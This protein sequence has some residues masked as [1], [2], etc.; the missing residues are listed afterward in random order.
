MVG[1]ES[2]SAT[3]WNTS[4]DV[5][6]FRLNS[7]SFSAS[8]ELSLSP[9]LELDIT[10]LDVN[11]LTARVDI[12]TPQ[13]AANASVVANVNRQC[14]PI[15]PNDFESFTAALTFGASAAIDIEVSTS[16]KLVPDLDDQIFT[17]NITL[18][19]LPPANAPECFIIADSSAPVG[20][21]ANPNSNEAQGLAGLVPV[22]TG[23]LLAATK[24]IP[25]FDLAK[26]KS[27]YSANGALPTNVNYTQ[28]VEATAVP[29]DIKNAVNKIVASS[30][31]SSTSM[32]RWGI[33]L[34][35]TV[36]T[37]AGI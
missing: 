27:Y 25:T 4:F 6:P 33:V 35:V 9:F 3:G 1:N 7:G 15:G 12:N 23:T 20:N 24:A 34:L 32:H 31:Q 17:D 29:A 18:G 28:L 36:I 11:V 8:A 21:A 19:S 30:G 22:P 10:L 37:L 13:I 5:I 2:S 14:Q 16:G 26:I